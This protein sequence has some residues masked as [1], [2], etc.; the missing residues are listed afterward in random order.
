[1]QGAEAADA[2]NTVTVRPGAAY[3]LSESSSYAYLQLRLQRLEG[4]TWVDVTSSEITAPEP[5]QTTTYRFVNAAPPALALPVTGGLG[6]DAYL[7]GGLALLVL[8]AAALLIRM[9]VIRL[10]GRLT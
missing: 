8:A 7:F 10:R 5:G 2:D 6:A 3:A 4:S 9:R 1:M